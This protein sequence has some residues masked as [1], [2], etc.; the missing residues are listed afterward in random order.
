MDVAAAGTGAALFF[1][2]EIII[3]LLHMDRDYR[4][5]RQ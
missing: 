3:N 5:G 4:L 1:E 2:K